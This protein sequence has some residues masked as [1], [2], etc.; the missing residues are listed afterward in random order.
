[1]AYALPYVGKYILRSRQ[2]VRGQLYHERCIVILKDGL[3][4][5]IAGQYSDYYTDKIQ[6]EYYQCPALCKEG[7]RHKA[8]NRQLCRAAHKWQQQYRHALVLLVLHGARAH[9]G[10]HSAAEAHQQG[11]EALSGKSE[12]AHWLIHDKC[13]TAHVAAVIQYGKEEKQYG[14]LGQKCQHAS[15]ACDYAVAY[16]TGQPF[17]CTGIFKR[18]SH[19]RRQDVI[20]KHTHKVREPRAHS[21]EGK[22]KYQKHYAYEYWKGKILVG[23]HP[24]YL[25]RCC[26]LVYW[27]APAKRRS[28]HPGNILISCIGYHALAVAEGG[29]IRIFLYYLIHPLLHVLWQGKLFYGFAVA[30]HELH[31]RPVEGQAGLLRVFAHKIAYLV[32][33]RVGIAVVYIVRLYIKAFVKLGVGGVDD[34]LYSVYKLLHALAAAG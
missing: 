27:V 2:P 3:A 12:A 18:G 19:I 34:A 9:S 15:H 17:H 10:R 21:T 6:A 14:Y 31:L 24:V 1:M 7:P 13:Y 23:E 16:E 29:G 20:Y 8:V 4:E 5:Q 22:R 33:Q 26:K 30:L 28:A 25:V 11:Y 32:M